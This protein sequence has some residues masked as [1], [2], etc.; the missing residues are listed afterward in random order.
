MQKSWRLAVVAFLSCHSADFAVR[1]RAIEQDPAGVGPE[2]HSR[3]WKS[4]GSRYPVFAP[5]EHWA[6]SSFGGPHNPAQWRGIFISTNWRTNS[7][8]MCCISNASRAHTSAALR[9]ICL[10]TCAD[11]TRNLLTRRVGYGVRYAENGSARSGP[12]PSLR[13]EDTKA[14]DDLRISTQRLRGEREAA[15]SVQSVPIGIHNT[16]RPANL[17][18]NEHQRLRRNPTHTSTWM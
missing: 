14:T 6:D 16:R 9:L 11:G 1:T 18:S 4:T 7:A 12:C 13:R 10:P 8:S 2:L 5:S 15:I 3:W 17:A